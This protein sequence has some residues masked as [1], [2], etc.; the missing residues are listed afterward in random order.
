MLLGRRTDR[1]DEE[2]G[3]L[4]IIKDLAVPFPEPDGTSSIWC[5]ATTDAEAAMSITGYGVLV[6]RVTAG[7]AESE[8]QT[9]HYQVRVQA[10][11]VDYRIAVNVRSAQNPP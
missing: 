4:F 2:T 6:G 7:T 8:L 10:A 9:P 5:R 11:G 3:P 1:D